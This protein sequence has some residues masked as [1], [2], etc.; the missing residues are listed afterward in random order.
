MWL[1]LAALFV[2][3]M[4]H[5]VFEPPCHERERSLLGFTTRSKTLIVAGYLAIP[6]AC[7]IAG[8]SLRLGALT[9]AAGSIAWHWF[10]FTL[11]VVFGRVGYLGWT[12]GV[13]A[14]MVWL[15]KL[16]TDPLT[17]LVAYSP[18]RL[19]RA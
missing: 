6:V 8:G 9:A 19:V 1:G 2:R 17:D 10:V 18:R 7:L 13:R 15:V 11:L 14:S 12:H 5:A 4:G 3:Q 16:V